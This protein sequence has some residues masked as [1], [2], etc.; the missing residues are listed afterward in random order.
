MLT[1]PLSLK[2]DSGKGAGVKSQFFHWR[3][4][5]TPVTLCTLLIFVISLWSL[6][7]YISRL[8]QD[9][10]QRVLGEQ[11]FATV[12]FIAAQVNDELSERLAALEQIAKQIDPPLMGDPAALQARLDQRLTLQLLFNGGIFITDRDGTAIADVPLSAGRIGTNYMDRESVSIP[13]KEGKT[14]IGKPAMGKK[15]EAPI[16]S[17]VAPIRDAPGKVIGAVVA[18]VN[19]GNPNFLDKITQGHYG[20]SGGYLLIAPQHNLFVTATDKKRIMQPL[21]APGLNAMHDRYMQGYEGFGL[22]VNSTGVLD[23]SAAKGIHAAGWFIVA[24]LPAEEAF[25]PIDAMVKRMLLG[26]LVIT[27]MASTLTW[28]LITRLLQR[29]LA[30]MLAA[31]R[32]L[33]TLSANDQPVQALPVT[34]QDEIG[35]LIG[36]FNHLL[37]TLGKRE[38]ELRE[39]EFRWKFAIEGAGDGVWDWNIQSGEVVYSRRWKEMLGFAESE[40]RNDISEWANRVHT[41]DMPVVMKAIQDHLDGKTP[42]ATVEFRML[43]KD[44]S[45]RWMLGRGM[46]VSLDSND[47]PVRLIG[48]TTDITERKQ[49]EAQLIRQ[50]QRAEALLQLPQLSEELDE[51]DFMQRSLTLA[52][53]LTGSL[54]SFMHFVNDDEETIELVTWSQRTISHYCQA[55]FDRHY[56]VSVAGIWADAVRQRAPVVCNDYAIY[57]GKRGLPDGHAPLLRFVSV[58]VFEQGKVVMLTG[59]GNRAAAYDEFDLESVQLISND[60]WHIVQRRR[61]Q[62]EL[63]QQKA[64]LEVRVTQRTA[65]LA[66]ASKNAEAANVAKSAF[67]A[68]MSHEIRTPMNGIIGMANILRREG[69]SLQQAKR[70]DS[71]DVSARHL[72]S[73]ID[74]ILDLSKI[75]ADKITLEEAP[76]VVSNLLANVYSILS[77]RAAAKGIHL[78]VENAYLP[79][80]LVGDPTRLQQALLNYA[81]NAVKFTEAGS[82]TLRTLM[83]E[84][85]DHAVTVRFEVQDT[86]IGI[87]SEAMPRLF[88]AF[89]QAD[90]SMTRKYG[91]TGLGLAITRRL[92]EL[93]DGQVGADSKAGV[94]STFW[95]TAKLKKGKSAAM[96]V[97]T[98]T[99]GDAEAELRHRYAGERILVVDDE[100]INRDVALLELEVVDLLVDTAENGAEAVA[101]ARK[102]SYAAIFMDMQMPKLNGLEATRQIRQFPGYRDIPI[103]AMTANAFAEDKAQ[104]L[105]AGMSDLLPKPF[106]PQGLFAMLLRLLKRRPG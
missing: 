77:E 62:Q 67:L 92:A 1:S 13:L 106:V 15:L 61:D 57:R 29:Q 78:L 22:A 8:L 86:G 32:Q 95:F 41:D 89:E 56:P 48:T 79:H 24:T 36:G 47:K 60:V 102:N 18:T 6:T 88:R 55:S 64:L 80:N 4:L 45:W 17:M 20:Q 75:D 81:T 84:E 103:I 99:D 82:V 35:E 66:V 26:A 87:N 83:Q 65:A 39:S 34:S 27:L 52:E 11:Q 33:A 19:L 31:S 90:N 96:V 72:L 97:P 59:V 9:D 38:E 93:M 70:L 50:K 28:W 85:T 40:I 23:L 68:N 37:E 49:A 21:P 76:I 10:M 94:G 58:P 3:S 69:V 98:E 53:D 25:A 100:P 2:P 46:V 12:S 14:L 43:C 105:A 7:F 63:E 5:K 74:D 91:G 44:A 71:I 73:I 101:L 54:V 30:P 42:P 51:H 104:C 16:F